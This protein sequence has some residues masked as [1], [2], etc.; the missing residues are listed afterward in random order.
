MLWSEI[1]SDI[2]R[3]TTL[4][5]KPWIFSSSGPNN[6]LARAVDHST[7]PGTMVLHSVLLDETNSRCKLW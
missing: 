6:G 7:L 1:F 2:A 5:G 4:S 3:S